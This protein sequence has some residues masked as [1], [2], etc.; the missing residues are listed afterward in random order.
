[1]NERSTATFQHP[2]M[3]TALIAGMVFAVLGVAAGGA[4]ASDHTFNRG[5]SGACTQYAQQ[6]DRFPDV[7]ADATHARAIDCLAHWE[8][9]TGRDTDEAE[10]IYAPSD[11]VSRAAMASFVTRTLERLPAV[12]VPAPADDR[13][14]D[15]EA[16]VHADNVHILRAADVV[17]GRADGTYG[18]SQPVTRAAMASY[19]ARMIEFVT[20]EQIPVG[21]DVDPAF[22]DVDGV[23]AN[24]VNKLATLGIVQ[25]RG[26]G[27]YGPSQPV[28]RAAMVTFV[29]NSMDYLAFRGYLPVPFDIDVEAVADPGPANLN[30]RITGVVEDQFATGYFSAEIRFE[31]YRDGVLVLSSNLTSGLG[32][33]IEFRYNADASEGDT[34][35][36]VACVVSPADRTEI[37]APYCLDDDLDPIEDRRATSLTVGWGELAVASTAPAEG[38]FFGMALNIDPDDN[39]LGYQT[40]PT[41]DAPTDVPLSE[42]YIFEYDDTANFQ[43]ADETNVATEVFECAVEASIADERNP[44]LL[45][46]SRDAQ[47]WNTYAL[48]TSTDVRWCF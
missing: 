14:V 33:D 41:P 45:N 15:Y 29:A 11:E 28:T 35:R 5:L 44:H 25:G 30:Q 32:G 31:V 3:S 48:A 36:V 8:I 2:V 13:F 20:D 23:H 39:L 34:D 17:Q 16:G 46:I 38:E 9:A 6:L 40:L 22:P 21:D 1:M 26:E 47:G 4:Q 43:V 18:P 24:N 27:T 10:R 37:D 7:A 42:F 12:N 19:I